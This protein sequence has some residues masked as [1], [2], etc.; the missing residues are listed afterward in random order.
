MTSGVWRLQAIGTPK[1]LSPQ[2]DAARAEQRTL[3]LLTYLSLEGPTPRA[4]LAGLLWPDSPGATARNNLVHLLRRVERTHAPGLITPGDQLAP[5]PALSSDLRDLDDTPPDRLPLGDLLGGALLDD[6]PDLEEWLLA[7]REALT[8]RRCARLTAAAAAA[9]QSGDLDRAARLT[10]DLITLDPV[11]EE[12]YRHLMR[13]LHAA[14]DRPAALRA[15]QQCQVAL[16]RELGAAPLPDTQA[17]ARAIERDDPTAAPTARRPGLPLSVLRPPVLMGRA[18]QWAQMEAAWAAGQTIV[19]AGPG[20]SGKTR[21]MQDFLRRKGPALALEG[22]P[23]DTQ[24]PYAATAR[25]LRRTLRTPEQRAAL[26]AWVQTA[27]HPI[28]PDLFP[29]VGG[30]P[31]LVVDAIQFVYALAMQEVVAVAY[32]DTH[33]TDAASRDAGFHL[34]SDHFPLGRTGSMPRVICT[35]RRDALTPDHRALFERYVAAGHVAWIDLPPLSADET[36]ALVRTLDV[37]QVTAVAPQLAALSAGNPQVLLETVKH[38]IETGGPAPTLPAHSADVISSRLAA[39][40]TPAL[41]VARAAAILANDVHL[42]LVAETLQVPVLDV[43]AAWEELEDAQVMVGEQFS[44]DLLAE[45][46][47][48]ELPGR[49][50]QVL[51]RAAARALSGAAREP[52]RVAAHWLAGGDP[53]QAAPW[54]DRAGHA[55]WKSGRLREAAQFFAQAAEHAVSPAGAFDAL[56]RH[57]EMLANLND[58][59]HASAVQRLHERATTPLQRAAAWAEQYRTVEGTFD[60]DQIEPVVQAGLAALSAAEPG[61]AAW[62]VEAHL[63][64]GQALTAYLRGHH[65]EVRRLLQHLITLAERSDSLEW[66]A[67]AQEGLGL[68]LTHLDPRQARA[69]LERAEGLHLRRGDLIRAGSSQAK[70]IR[71]LCELGDVEAAELA[72]TRGA[73]HLALLDAHP[74]ERAALL[75]AQIM[76]AHLGG[77]LGAA[78]DLHAQALREHHPDQTA[79]VRVLPVLHARTLRLSGAY[80]QAQQALTAALNDA[81]FPSNY[82]ALL[83]LERIALDRAQGRV[84]DLL[85]LLHAAQAELDADPSVLWQAALHDHWAAHL[86]EAAPQG[87]AGHREAARNLRRQH[88]LPD[89]HW[90]AL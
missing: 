76:A 13:R 35:L 9:E 29:G 86:D 85:P 32:E 73:A 22:R 8:V 34:L 62:L 23:G 58:P 75:F 25:L 81:A 50:A 56:T 48:A 41:Q 60:P 21:L 84:G 57:A 47:R 79:L 12:P 14:G 68:A 18:R 27:L 45:T 11:A 70:L 30:A 31:D 66:Q 40:S 39:L 88:H 90:S 37:P 6:L 54:L 44:H 61:Q 20:G 65:G 43:A 38:L 33:L 5:G 2:G 28:A 7:A 69:H 64:E 24:W 51:H 19:L 82:R 80:P 49:V 63:T 4:R 83:F 59:A 89:R 87:G 17:L 78:S 53:G 67:K 46:L 71:V 3:A 16:A 15:Y 74:G 1:L 36:E 10:R 77:R 26:P 52:A 55:A 42:E 72:S